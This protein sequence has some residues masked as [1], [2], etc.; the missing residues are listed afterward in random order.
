MVSSTAQL[1]AEVCL[2]YRKIRKEEDTAYLQQDLDSLQLWENEWLIQCNLD[3]C[4]VPRV[5][6][7]RKPFIRNY[8]IHEKKKTLATV[9]QETIGTITKKA[10]NIND[11]LRSNISTCP[12]TIKAQC[13]FT[14]VRPIVEYASIIWDP[15]L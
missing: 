8:T 6:N 4:E 14:L 2:L 12:S 3:K 13:Y 1:F 7:K 15:V 11:L 10:S 9:N 5:I